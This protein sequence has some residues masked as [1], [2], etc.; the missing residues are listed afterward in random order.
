MIAS[1]EI[2]D[3]NVEHGELWGTIC[4]N[5]KALITTPSTC[6]RQEWL[7]YELPVK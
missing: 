6:G 3:M 5:D 7:G 4:S 2:A 1:Y